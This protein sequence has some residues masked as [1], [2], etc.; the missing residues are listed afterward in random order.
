[1][2]WGH[3]DLNKIPHFQGETS[4]FQ[5]ETITYS[6]WRKSSDTWGARRACVGSLFAAIP[7]CQWGC[8]SNRT[9][10]CCGSAVGREL[11]PI[12]FGG[13]QSAALLLKYFS[14]PLWQPE[15]GLPSCRLVAVSGNSHQ[16]HPTQLC[17][18]LTYI[19]SCTFNNFFR[20]N[21]S[22]QFCTPA[23]GQA[24]HVLFNPVPSIAW[25]PKLCPSKHLCCLKCC[26]CWM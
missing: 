22:N 2:I 24:D 21:S 13:C 1:M 26:S 4:H 23:T 5:T 16:P 9:F 8:V 19:L 3:C 7:S 18:L 10:S 15:R 14:T 11:T 20:F 17:N 25:S 6:P 12:S